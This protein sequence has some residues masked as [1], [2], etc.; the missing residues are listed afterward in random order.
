MSQRI[1]A[2]GLD[3]FEPTIASE[4][5]AGGELPFLRQLLERSAIFRLDHGEARFTGLAWEHFSTGK[6]PGDYRRW[7]AVDFDPATYSIVQKATRHEPFTAALRRRVMAFDV[8]YH[9]LTSQNVSGLANWGAHDPGVHQHSR[10]EQLAREIEDRF[11]PYPAKQFIYGYVWPDAVRTAQ[12]GRT[13]DAALRLRSGIAQWL[14]AERLPDWEL[15]IIVVSE[16]HS[17]LEALWHGWDKSHPLN[18]LPS[19]AACA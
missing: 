19:A 2:I 1:I 14:M 17:A 16:F 5:I 6:T 3:G 13:L 12:M 18:G 4:L 8:P 9:E 7:S 10:P 11:G 15:A